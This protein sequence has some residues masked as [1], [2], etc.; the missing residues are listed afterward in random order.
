MW[1]VVEVASGIPVAVR[2]FPEKAAAKKRQKFLR[3]KMRP[4][5]DEVGVFEVPIASG[6]D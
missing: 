2:T 3:S 6:T 1:V 4:D 5:Y